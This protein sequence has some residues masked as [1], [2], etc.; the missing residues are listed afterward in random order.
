MTDESASLPTSPEG[1]EPP[2]RRASNRLLGR[3]LPLVVAVSVLIAVVLVVPWLLPKD[4][5]EPHAED[6]I[7]PIPPISSSQEPVTLPT[8]SPAPS[9]APAPEPESNFKSGIA[10]L[11]E[12]DLRAALPDLKNPRIRLDENAGFQMNSFSQGP[13]VVGNTWVVLVSD[14]GESKTTKLLVGISAA[15][16]EVLWR[17]ASNRNGDCDVLPTVPALVCAEH[18]GAVFMVS[19]S[20]N[21]TDIAT[22]PAKEGASGSGYHV[23]V[24]AWVGGLVVQAAAY[25]G[26][27]THLFG[28]DASGAL[29]WKEEIAGENNG[30][31]EIA[32]DAF[33]VRSTAE[34]GNTQVLSASTGQV[35]A[36]SRSG[37]SLL[38]PKLLRSSGGIELTES[39]E[40]RFEVMNSESRE[41]EYVSRPDGTGILVRASEE[42]PQVCRDQTT[43]SCLAVPGLNEKWGG[44]VLLRRGMGF[45]LVNI[46]GVSNVLIRPHKDNSNR[47]PVMRTYA[48]MPLDFSKAPAHVQVLQDQGKSWGVSDGFNSI[49]VGNR[50]TGELV[51]TD[52]GTGAELGMQAS[53]GWRPIPRMPEN[54]LLLGRAADPSEYAEKVNTLSAWGPS[55]ELRP[56]ALSGETPARPT[57]VESCPDGQKDLA[58]GEFDGGWVLVCGSDLGSAK[59][60]VANIDGTRYVA[61]KPVLKQGID[62]RFE[63]V[64][65]DGTTFGISHSPGTIAKKDPEGR[66]LEQ[67]RLGSVWFAA[68]NGLQPREGAFGIKRPEATAE[69]QLRYLEQL[70]RSG[71]SDAI[72][73][74]ETSH[75]ISDCEELKHSSDSEIYRRRIEK[76]RDAGMRRT[77]L[78]AAIDAAP[79]DQIPDGLKLRNRL[80]NALGWSVVAANGHAEL[81]WRLFSKGCSADETGSIFLGETVMADLRGISAMRATDHFVEYWNTNFAGN[82]GAERLAG[83]IW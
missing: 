21:R 56:W 77:E 81:G 53:E 28:L 41:Y 33:L 38:G 30:S 4:E 80:M 10:K 46:D 82:H 59:T 39:G 2:R 16:G 47:S 74:F 83:G 65:A 18:S 57:Q 12:L 26:E 20:G 17:M 67:R 68:R 78:F 29:A 32:G 66:L 31:L 25:G 3:I 5:P 48:V 55:E 23:G 27:M 37:I 73:Y 6:T 75:K 64:T 8:P 50:E 24:D 72:D 71:S 79:V 60:L 70:I 14:E 61:E 49:S 44:D 42:G 54:R 62:L 22:L 11:W 13:L 69:G 45:S 58:W 15:T 76:M 52:Q 63:G 19:E 34:G 36:A 35:L 40:G 1:S 9:P 51:V 43:S 7:P